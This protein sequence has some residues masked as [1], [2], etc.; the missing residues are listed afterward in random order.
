MWACMEEVLFFSSRHVDGINGK[1]EK[2]DERTA[3]SKQNMDIVFAMNLYL[4][5]EGKKEMWMILH[6]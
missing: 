1:K 6:H 5:R 2:K 3:F 4:I